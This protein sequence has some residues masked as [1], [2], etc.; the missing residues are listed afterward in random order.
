GRTVTMRLLDPQF[1]DYRSRIGIDMPVWA[2]VDK[3]ELLTAVKRVALVAERNTAVRLTFTD[4]EVLVQAGGGDI[5]RGRNSVPATLDGAGSFE[6]AFQPHY[7]TTAIEGVD[8]TR[9]RIGMTGPNKPAIFTGDGA[10]T[11]SYRCLGMSL[12]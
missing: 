10:D 11:G 8:E 5:G 2:T 3:S 12:R 6:I 7:L 4:D 1:V 9:V